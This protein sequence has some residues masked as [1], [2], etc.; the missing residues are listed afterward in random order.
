MQT[1]TPGSSELPR[2]LWLWTPIVFLLFILIM[3]GI[4]EK[5]ARF[6]VGD[7]FGLVEPA[8][9]LILIPAVYAGIKCFQYKYLLPNKL[10]IAWLVLITLGCVYIAGEEISWGQHYFKW[11]TPEAVQALNDQQET[12]IHNIS[13]WFD[14]KPRL[15][16]E[17]WIIIGGIF[18]PAYRKLRKKI[19][20]SD[21]WQ[22]WF[23]PSFVCFPT[24]IIAIVVKLPERYENLFGYWPTP[25][26]IR[27]SELQEFYF[28][29]FLFI[30]L[31]SCMY[32]VK[33]LK[34]AI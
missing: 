17:I 7:E 12:N 18:L 9:A 5:Q 30:Y 3:I 19:F 22:Y 26:I 24:A 2:W 10:I 34:A 1:Q 31:M 29:L 27:F 23:W 25:F 6:L 16:L 20:S 4:D 8:T 15:L 33:S 13:S 21:Q 32:R 28:S 14:Q 11:Q